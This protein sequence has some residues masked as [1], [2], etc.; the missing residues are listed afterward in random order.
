MCA[1][2]HL[3]AAAGLRCALASS[4]E[5]DQGASGNKTINHVNGKIRGRGEIEKA[6]RV[7]LE[8]RQREERRRRGRR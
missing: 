7:D 3:L 4:L 6:C 8:R 5:D 2:A 1:R